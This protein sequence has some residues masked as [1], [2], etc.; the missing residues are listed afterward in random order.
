MVSLRKHLHKHYAL[1][2]RNI[3]SDARYF[4]IVRKEN[5]MKKHAYTMIAI[6]LITSL[7]VA[8]GTDNTG[9]V[10]S[11]EMVPSA[12]ASAETPP[13]EVTQPPSAVDEEPDSVPEGPT[14]VEVTY[15]LTDEAVTLT[16]WSEQPNLGPLRMW[17][18]DYGVDVFED[19]S[20][21]QYVNEL[22]GVHVSFENASMENAATMFNL[23]IASGDWADMICGPDLYYAGGSGKAYSDGVLLDL[24][25][26]LDEFAPNYNAIL[27]SDSTVYR[28]AANDD[29]NVIQFCS[30]LGSFMQSEGTIIR[31]DWL[32]RVQMEVPTTIRELH[33]VLKAFQSELGCANPF[34]MNSACNQLLTSYNLYYYQEL[35]AGDLAVYQID[36]TAYSSFTSDAYCSWLETMHQWYTEGLIDSDFISVSSSMF[37]G[38]DEELL[39]A[40]NI[41]VWWGNINS[42]TN[43]Y[44][45]CPAEGFDIVPTFIYGTDEKA[46]HI[47]S[48]STVFAGGT[49]LS[50]TCSRPELACG[51]L[52]YWYGDEG[53]MLMNYG[54]EGESYE[55]KDGEVQYT[56]L[57]TNSAFNI[58]SAVA[59]KL[60][61]IAGCSFGIQLDERTFPFY[62]DCQLEAASD[63][64]DP[65]DGAWAYPAVTLT[66]EESDVIGNRGPD[67]S[68]Y[69]SEN[70]P[71][72]IMGELSIADEWDTFV[73]TINSMGMDACIEA[74][75]AALNRYNAV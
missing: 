44:S 2:R 49:A 55:L 8:C 33:D 47:T 21:I 1:F 5:S 18:G 73:S 40:D 30:L 42:M 20:S 23:H 3:D 29:G 24:S 32:D 54:I 62:I 75:Q 53:V 26:Y 50:A 7:L 63:W 65:C 17:G 38:H 56:E 36:G 6:L 41:G 57:V 74:Y 9:A 12:S 48:T 43:Y 14:P 45:I 58:D 46:N 39:A 34:Y 72:F 35:S 71:R 31:K 19:Y 51:W 52:D 16:M 22:T 27:G 13:P 64:T 66:T 69:I 59:L 61:S 10:S 11:G 25:E 37:G 15:P 28:C 68:T 67:V 70:V 4:A 60:Y